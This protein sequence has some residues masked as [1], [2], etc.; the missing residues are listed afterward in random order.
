MF[1]ISLLYITARFV[2]AKDHRPT[3]AEVCDITLN[4]QGN[5]I[6]NDI[7]DLLKGDTLSPRSTT[8]I[9]VS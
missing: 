9:H 8:S 4:S 5:L 2:L 3:Y 7:H 1:C 6:G